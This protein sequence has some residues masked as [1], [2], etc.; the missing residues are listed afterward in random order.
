M[1]GFENS[2]VVYEC[3]NIEAASNQ[4]LKYIIDGR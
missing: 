4:P 3:E 1:F 2:W